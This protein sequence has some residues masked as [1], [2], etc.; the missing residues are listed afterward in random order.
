LNSGSVKRVFGMGEKHYDTGNNFYQN[1][2]DKRLTYTCGYWGQ[3]NT[4]DEAQEAKLDLVCRKLGLKNGDKILDIGCGWGSFIKYAVEKYGVYAVGITVSEEEAKIA[5][6]LCSGLSAEI[7]IQDYRNINVR[8]KFDH[9]VSLEM[10]ENVGT[11]NYKV[12]MKKVHE[13]LEDDGLFLLHTVGRNKTSPTINLW[14]DK[15]IFPG[16]M[17]PS[18][19]QIGDSTEDFFVMEDWHNFGADYDKTLLAWY[20]NFEGNW[21]K[22]KSNY[23]DKFYRMWK[24]YLLSFA[25]SFRARKNQLW[26][27]VLSKKGILSGYKSIR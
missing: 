7:R 5:S 20:N 11:K 23:D 6:K 25:G 14:V 9:I 19:K 26:Q 8:E 18:I 13:L 1:I 4:L 2:L 24:Y 15:Y 16:G 10:F 17:L 12:Y 21:D 3:V 22:I 27:I